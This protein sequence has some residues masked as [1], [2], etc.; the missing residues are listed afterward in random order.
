LRCA[1]KLAE[2]LPAIGFE[3]QLTKGSI[4]QMISL[5][6]L[7]LNPTLQILDVH[8][9]GST[10]PDDERQ[11]WSSIYLK[12]SDSVHC[13]TVT[14]TPKLNSLVTRCERSQLSGFCFLN[15]QRDIDSAETHGKPPG[16]LG[17]Q[18]CDPAR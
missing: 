14:L 17:L 9:A 18:G 7:A 11:R 1:A 6:T 2:S 5:D 13:T 8:A 16:F 4:Q 10:D 15:D 12:L 3:V